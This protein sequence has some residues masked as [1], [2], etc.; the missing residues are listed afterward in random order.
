MKTKGI[1]TQKQRDEYR[2]E[3]GTQEYKEMSAKGMMVSIF[4][5]GELAKDDDYLKSYRMDLGEKL[6]NV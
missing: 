4:S 6:F 1:N 3:F 5:Y 2:P